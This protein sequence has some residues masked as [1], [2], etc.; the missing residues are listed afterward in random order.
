MLP[1]GITVMKAHWLIKKK[2][3]ACDKEANPEA[4]YN[5]VMMTLLDMDDPNLVIFPTHRLLHGLKLEVI[6]NLEEKLTAY[7]DIEDLSLEAPDVWQQ[8]DR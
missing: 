1:T 6:S 3:S 8:V 7:F 4:A 2:R 5:F